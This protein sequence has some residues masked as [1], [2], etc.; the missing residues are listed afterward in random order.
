MDLR[1]R[2]RRRFF[3]LLTAV[4]LLSGALVYTTFSGG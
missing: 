1:G 3:G 4:V 2:R